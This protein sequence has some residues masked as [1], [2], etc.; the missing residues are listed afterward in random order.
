MLQKSAFYQQEMFDSFLVKFEDSKFKIPR[1]SP[2]ISDLWCSPTPCTVTHSELSG[3][4]TLPTATPA[5]LS[6]VIIYVRTFFGSLILLDSR[7]WMYRIVRKAMVTASCYQWLCPAGSPWWLQLPPFLLSHHSVV[8]S[9]TP[10][11]TSIA[12]ISSWSRLG[13]LFGKPSPSP[14]G[15]LWWAISAKPTISP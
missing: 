8:A 15:C 2:I 14:L 10:R 7:Q 4:P 12:S 9:V 6:A 13:P 3:S 1:K 11:Q 5:V